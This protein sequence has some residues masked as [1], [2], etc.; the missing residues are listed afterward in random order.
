M[1][2]HPEIVYSVI[3]HRGYNDEIPQILSQSS[4]RVALLC[5]GDTFALDT[6]KYLRK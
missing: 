4:S 1:A 3:D 5:S 6:M 2:V